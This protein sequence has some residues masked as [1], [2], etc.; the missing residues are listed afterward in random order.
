MAVYIFPVTHTAP[1]VISLV[2]A[3][4]QLKVDFDDDDTLITSYIDAAIENCENYT[5]TCINEAKFAFKFSEFTNDFVFKISPIQSIDS[6]KYF[7]EAGDEQILETE[8]Y[9]LLPVDKFTHKVHFIDQDTL[10]QVAE[11]KSNAVVIEVT[12]GYADGKVPKAIKSA[13][14]LVLTDLYEN[15][16]DRVHKMPTRSEALLRKYRFYY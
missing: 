5:G 14:L 11:N 15:R 6:I 1:E 9:E 13:A 10:P 4:L 7:D 8:K 3:K 12:S 16:E 2:T